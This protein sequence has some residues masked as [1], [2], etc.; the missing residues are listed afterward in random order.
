MNVIQVLVSCI[1]LLILDISWIM[2]VMKH[3]YNDMI[4]R[5]QNSPMNVNIWYAA[6]AY[7]L[8]LFGLIWFVLRNIK[9]G[10]I[11]EK[12]RDSFLNGFTFGVVL[13]GLYNCT[14]GSLFDKWSLKITLMDCMWGGFVYFI[15]AFLGSL[16][17]MNNN[18]TN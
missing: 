12:L 9:D 11:L 10:T 6:V 5:I 2:L 14:A 15:S 1:V 17:K 3:Q 16:V 7:M 13:Y 18:K 4:P 8:M